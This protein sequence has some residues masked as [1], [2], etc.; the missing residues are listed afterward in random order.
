MMSNSESGTLLVQVVPVDAGREIGW[1]S[2]AA[3]RLEDRLDD[4]RGAIA[5]GAK[6]VADSLDGLP[7]AKGWRLG[8]VSTKFGVTLAAQAGVIF[9]SASAGTT[10]E[11]TVRYMHEQP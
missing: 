7:S 10:F 6:S 8:E 9:S 3:E 11:V 2:A 1:G 5:A 4:I